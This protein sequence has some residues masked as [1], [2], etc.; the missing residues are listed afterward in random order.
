[1]A[2]DRP[3]VLQTGL[4]KVGVGGGGLLRPGPRSGR[5][6]SSAFFYIS[7]FGKVH[8]RLK[9]DVGPQAQALSFA[10]MA[11]LSSSLPTGA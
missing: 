6:E 7:A 10:H 3:R 11:L 1:M 4:I 5:A 2:N 8:K 9:A